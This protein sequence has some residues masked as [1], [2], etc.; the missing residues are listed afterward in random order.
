MSFSTVVEIEFYGESEGLDI[1]SRKSNILKILEKDGI[2]ADVYTDLVELFKEQKHHFNLHPVYCF[3]LLEKVSNLFP[4]S[5]FSS[6]GLG[7]EY[8]FTWVS[9]FE[10]GETSFKNLAWDNENPFI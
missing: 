10:N 4:E 8:I 3:E 2:H 7:E 5:D 6:R 9:L 1:E